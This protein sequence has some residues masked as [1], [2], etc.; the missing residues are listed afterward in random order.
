MRAV[1]VASGDPH[2]DDGRWLEGA[3]LIVAVDAGAAWL[4]Q[5]AVRPHALVGD[6]DS[7]DAELVRSLA[8]AGVAI[9]RHPIDK[10]Q[11][12]TEL[13]IAFARSKGADE[14]T[15]L[16]AFGGS[17]LDHEIANLILL[18][19]SA[20]SGVRLVHGESQVTALHGDDERQLAG[21]DGSLVSLFAAGGDAL[22]VTTS[23]LEYP[24]RDETLLTGS[25]RGLSNVILTRPASVRLRRGTLLVVEQ[26]EDG[27]E[28]T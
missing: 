28:P 26:P 25:S 5:H 2:P 20:G 14:I 27:D 10:D 22:G 24:L 15:V 9:E 11:S 7:V 4:V 8:A 13:A 18:S 16:G 23:G 21:P 12:D 6:L 17:R 1:L 3:D 19:G